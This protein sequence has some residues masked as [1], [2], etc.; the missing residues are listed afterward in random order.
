MRH[1]WWMTV[2][3]GGC[4]G[5]S[6]VAMVPDPAQVGLYA[7]EFS[8]EVVHEQS[9]GGNRG[10]RIALRGVVSVEQDTI[11]IDARH[12]LCH[13]IN[14]PSATRFILT[15]DEYSFSFHRQYPTS[16][17][18]YTGSVPV[19]RVVQGACAEYRINPDGSRTCIRYERVEVPGFQQV[20]GTLRLRPIRGEVEPPGVGGRGEKGGVRGKR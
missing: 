15:C 18:I 8:V 5:G 17:A 19:V 20:R 7:Y 13:P 3:I 1:L 6:P 14:Q 2:M 9:R 11:T 12:G 16:A 4:A 10:E